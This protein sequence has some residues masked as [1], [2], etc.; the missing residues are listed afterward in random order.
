MCEPLA[1][2]F[3][4]ADASN[5]V[6]VDYRG[7]ADSSG[8]PSEGGLI[9]DAHSTYDWVAAKVKGAGFRQPEKQIIIMGHSL[10]TGVTSALTGLLADAGQF[11]WG[12]VVN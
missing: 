3:A 8:S 2:E 12:E 5:V 11:M 10:G 1:H 9:V 4:E 6:A 7:F